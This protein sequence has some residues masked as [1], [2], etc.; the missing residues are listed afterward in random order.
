MTERTARCTYCSVEKPSS[1]A[2]PFFEF[3]GEGSR[4][5]TEHCKCGYTLGCHD[6]AHP[7]VLKQCTEP[8][9]TARGPQEFDRFY[10]G[11]RGWD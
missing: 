1:K 4:E 6:A 7:H 11:C 10:C 5:A 3:R 2:L 8:T 9:P